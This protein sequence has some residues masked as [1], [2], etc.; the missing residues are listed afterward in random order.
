MARRMVDE[1]KAT[2]GLA[3]TQVKSLIGSQRRQRDTLRALG[4]RR[5]HQ[6]VTQPDRPEI[7]GM[8]ARVAHLVQVSYGAD[9][10]PLE[11]APG[12]EPK[13][14]G[15][16]PAGHAVADD[17]A[18]EREDALTEALAEPGSADPASLVQHPPTLTATDAPDAPKKPRT[19]AS[20]EE[21]TLA[22]EPQGDET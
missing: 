2:E 9:E 6:T 17:E 5:M 19:P 11:L 22:V 4:L 1:P 3:I 7:R 20:E 13:G 16:P 12:Q 14:A 21:E 15:N 10:Q 8:I 18:A